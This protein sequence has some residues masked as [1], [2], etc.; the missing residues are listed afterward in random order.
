MQSRGHRLDVVVADGQAPRA[1]EDVVA[2]LRRGVAEVGG[3]EEVAG[4]QAAVGGAADQPVE[5]VGLQA[6]AGALDVDGVAVDDVAG[7]DA[8]AATRLLARLTRFI[9]S[10]VD[11]A[12]RGGAA[13]GLLDLAD[14]HD[15]LGEL[16]GQQ[17]DLVVV[18]LQAAVDGEVLLDDAWP[19][20]PRRRPAR[21]SRARGRSSR[22]GSWPSSASR[23]EVAQVD[24]LERRRVGRLAVQQ[25]V[26]RAAGRA[27]GRR[28]RG[29]RPRST[30][31][32]RPP[33]ACRMPRPCGA[34][35]RGWS[36][37]RRRPSGPGCRSRRAVDAGRVPGGA[38][39][40][41]ADVA[42]VVEDLEELVGGAG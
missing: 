3:V 12:A 23:V 9:I 7:L 31:R 38:H 10:P 33:S 14:P 30:S 37:R 26:G 17:A 8:R 22:P 2:T 11:T 41:D 40:V 35:A 29:S 28:S 21:G 1:T 16:A 6:A 5:G 18:A 19:R 24:V 32:S 4:V 39:D 13:Q 20:A 27:A 25:R 36:G 34:A 42:A 15:H